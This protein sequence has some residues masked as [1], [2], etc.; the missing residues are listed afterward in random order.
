MDRYVPRLRKLTQETRQFESHIPTM[1]F[2]GYGMLAPVS[3][4]PTVNLGIKKQMI[5]GHNIALMARIEG[6]CRDA[7][8]EGLNPLWW[9]EQLFRLPQ[10]VLT[11]FGVTPE[12]LASKILNVLYWIAAGAVLLVEPWREAAWQWLARELSSW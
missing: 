10:S 1:Q 8:A 6:A 2:A 3:V 9:V 12:H 5:F 4:Q 11:Y 7:V